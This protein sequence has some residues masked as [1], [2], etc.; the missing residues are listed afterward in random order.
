MEVF[1]E[2]MYMIVIW[3]MGMCTG[4]GIG[5]A[6]ASVRLQKQHYAEMYEVEQV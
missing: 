2:L 5:T 3:A 1:T 4:M 6:I